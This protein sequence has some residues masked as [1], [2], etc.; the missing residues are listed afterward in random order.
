MRFYLAA[1]LIFLV[2]C[3]QAR[4]D[5]LTVNTEITG[6]PAVAG[7][8]VVFHV[9]VSWPGHLNR[10]D[11]VKVDVPSLTNLELVGRGM[12]NKTVVDA[13]GRKRAVKTFDFYL[14]PVEPVVATIGP[15]AVHYVNDKGVAVRYDTRPR[16]IQVFR[17][18]P[19][20]KPEFIAGSIFLWLV[21][22][23]FGMALLFVLG[24]FLW[25]R[26]QPREMT[27]DDTGIAGKYIN[28]LR[29][30]VHP[31]NNRHKDNIRE[32]V[33]ILNG[34][35]QEKYRETETQTP[36]RLPGRLEKLFAGNSATAALIKRITALSGDNTVDT[37]VSHALYNALEDFLMEEKRLEKR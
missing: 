12:S 29:A 19:D 35:I 17:A 3:A 28:L 14:K 8:E 4:P 31:A 33:R 9:R 2:A 25:L 22:L 7:Q 20:S 5:S 30:T 16:I 1:W 37:H 34:Y 26:R 23:V 15:V 36:A 10:F 11:P 18:S 21:A 32:M 27:E 13:E 24:R 6:V